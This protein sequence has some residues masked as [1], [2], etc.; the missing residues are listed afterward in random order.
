[1]SDKFFRHDIWSG[2]MEP[3]FDGGLQIVPTYHATL[4]GA[5]GELSHPWMDWGFDPP[6]GDWLNDLMEAERDRAV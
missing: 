4:L 3:A 2:N 1:M 6:A 5:R